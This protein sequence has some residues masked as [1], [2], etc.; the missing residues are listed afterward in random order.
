M[1]S[2]SALTNF[3]GAQSDALLS[4]RAGGTA[5]AGG[6]TDTSTVIDLVNGGDPYTAGSGQVVH[7]LKLAAVVFNFTDVDTPSTATL[8]MTLQ[9]SNSASFASGNQTVWTHVL[10]SA[11]NDSHPLQIVVPFLNQWKGT[12]YRYVRFQIVSANSAT[13]VYG[14][15]MTKAQG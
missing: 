2:Y 13:A 11:D 8:T 5:I 10:N 6:A 7:P 9:L 12:N 3:F 1:A 15:E 14:A 4:M